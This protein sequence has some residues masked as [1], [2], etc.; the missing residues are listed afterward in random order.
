MSQTVQMM[1]AVAPGAGPNAFNSQ[2]GTS[3]TADA[4]GIFAIAANDIESAVQSGMVPVYNSGL[5]VANYGIVAAATVG[6]FVASAALSNGALTIANQPDCPRQAKL[7]VDPGPSAITAGTATA[8]YTANDG[9]TQTDVLSLVTGASTVATLFFSKGVAAITSITVA[10]LT[11]GTSPKVQVDSTAVL[12]LPVIPNFVALT[13]VYENVDAAPETV[14]S[15]T[16]SNGAITPTTAPNGT[17]TYSFGYTF[18]AP[19]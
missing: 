15:V 17:H 12:A 1:Y 2:L 13:G 7:R 11:G 19:A 4:N 3:Y 8:I 16:T 18:K 10:G 5:R 14:G 6:K 9:S